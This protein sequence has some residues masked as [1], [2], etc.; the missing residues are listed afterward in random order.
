MSANKLL[1]IKRLKGDMVKKRNLFISF[2]GFWFFLILFKFGGGLH[3]ALISPLGERVM[4]LWIVGILMSIA[5]VIQLSL[6]IPAGKILDK[7]G[8]KK[9]LS[10]A[11]FIFI[12]STLLL[13]FGF[14]A[15]FLVSSV[16]LAS[17]AWLFLGPGVN[18]YVLSHAKKTESGRFMA[19]RDIFGSIGIILSAIALPFAIKFS[20]ST[21][22]LILSLILLASF[23]FILLSPKDIR[24]IRPSDN[25]HEKTHH[26]RRYL[27]A[28]L[29]KAIK[30]L[31]PAST[32]LLSLNFVGAL[33][34]GVVWFVVPLVIAH[35]ENNTHLLG[36]GLGMFDFAVVIVGSLLYTFIDKSN[37][38]RLIFIGLIIFSL[39]SILLGLNYG[40]LFLVFAFLSTTGD[41]IASLPLWAWL[42]Q[43][44]KNHNEDGLISGIINLFSD[45]GWAVGP[46]IA[47]VLYQLVGPTKTIMIGA[48]PIFIMAI[49]YYFVM[50][51]NKIKISKKNIPKKPHKPRHK[52]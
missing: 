24:K 10:I 5:S 26:Q 7:Y 36:I 9:M 3:Y 33:F 19:S 48:A 16:L 31:N 47:G 40:I 12:A 51:K 37:K 6:D 32:L 11:A 14:D 1:Y 21:I 35:T 23:I 25:V 2:V 27:F 8:Y 46:L 49:S 15:L 30:G 18:A 45:L 42:H 29:S 28:N 38:K 34:Y 44:D 22:G 41:E 52:T 43:L 17:F 39:A 20:S 4:P 50:R 13:Y